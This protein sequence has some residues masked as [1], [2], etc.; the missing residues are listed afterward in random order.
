MSPTSGLQPRVAVVVSPESPGHKRATAATKRPFR[1]CSCESVSPVKNFSQQQRHS[2]KAH[3]EMKQTGF[4]QKCCMKEVDLLG[5]SALHL[6]C[7]QRRRLFCTAT[8]C[9]SPLQLLRKPGLPWREGSTAEWR[10]QRSGNSPCTGVSPQPGAAL[11]L[12]SPGSPA[13][14]LPPAHTQLPLPQSLALAHWLSFC[15]EVIQL[16]C[17]L[18]LERISPRNEPICLKA[19]AQGTAADHCATFTYSCSG[20]KSP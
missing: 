2:S 12:S 7:L 10:N 11:L 16:F 9:S 15:A 4:C 8:A 5:I 18:L 19:L 14:S 13:S 3:H 6:P 17:S 1:S 20:V